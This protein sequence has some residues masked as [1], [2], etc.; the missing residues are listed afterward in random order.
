MD[1]LK[2]INHALRLRWLEAITCRDT[3]AVHSGA[4]PALLDQSAVVEDGIAACRLIF[5]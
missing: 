4:F 1:G 3:V 5:K 2:I